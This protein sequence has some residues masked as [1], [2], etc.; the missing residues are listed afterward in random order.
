MRLEYESAIGDLASK[1]IQE[2]IWIDPPSFC[3]Y[4]LVIHV[5]FD[6]INLRES[7][8]LSSDIGLNNEQFQ[9]AL[10]IMGL[11]DALWSRYGSEAA[12]VVLRVEPEWQ[13]I[14][15]SAKSFLAASEAPDA[16]KVHYQ[17]A[18][19][20]GK[21]FDPPNPFLDENDVEYLKYVRDNEEKYP[22]SN[23]NK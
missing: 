13:E 6:D 8:G 20:Y 14:V 2:Q 22:S 7:D 23:L 17:S 12:P 21:R 16:F 3:G 19:S 15:E 9:L 11:F 5:I 4:D 1:E 10:K 18:A